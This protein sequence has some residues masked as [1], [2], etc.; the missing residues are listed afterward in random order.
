MRKRKEDRIQNESENPSSPIVRASATRLMKRLRRN[1]SAGSIDGI[2][3]FETYIKMLP[4]T[5]GYTPEEIHSVFV[6][7]EKLKASSDTENVL[8]LVCQASLDFQK[9]SG[10]TEEERAHQIRAHVDSLFQCLLRLPKEQNELQLD[11]DQ[12]KLLFLLNGWYEEITIVENADVFLYEMLSSYLEKYWKEDLGFLELLEMTRNWVTYSQSIQNAEFTTK[13][14][15]MQWLKGKRDVKLIGYLKKC[16]EAYGLD[17]E[18]KSMK[19]KIAHFIEAIEEIETPSDIDLEILSQPNESQDTFVR[20]FFVTANS[21]MLPLAQWD[22]LKG[23]NQQN[24]S[25][26]L[27]LTDGMLLQLLSTCFQLTEMRISPYTA[28]RVLIHALLVHSKDWTPFFTRTLDIVVDLLTSFVTNQENPPET[29][30][31]NLKWVLWIMTHFDEGHRAI[32]FECLRLKQS[33]ILRQLDF[34]YQTPFEFL[35]SFLLAL[36]P[37]DLEMAWEKIKPYCTK[38]GIGC[39]LNLKCFFELPLSENQIKEILEAVSKNIATWIQ[40]S[41]ELEA[42]LFCTGINEFHRMQ[43]MTA[44]GAT[45]FEK[46]MGSVSDF[47]VGVCF[48]DAVRFWQVSFVEMTLTE[49]VARPALDLNLEQGNGRPP[50]LSLFRHLAIENWPEKEQVINIITTLLQSPCLKVS[51]QFDIN[52]FKKIDKTPPTFFKSVIYT[53]FLWCM[54]AQEFGVAKALMEHPSFN[55]EMEAV[56]L[57]GGIFNIYSKNLQQVASLVRSAMQKKQSYFVEV[58]SSKFPLEVPDAQKSC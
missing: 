46:L 2:E 55:W 15:I 3:S 58:L 27:I 50:L 56:R 43:I 20:H 4:S 57:A 24:K 26:Q 48:Q 44:I 9:T 17:P 1:Y 5:G 39:Y 32:F 36:S 25:D 11:R 6:Q 37:Q 22:F 41:E 30:L 21:A 29:L 18:E 34:L 42:L 12:Y 8:N 31:K 33:A 16:Y 14:A 51:F 45:H 47:C 13:E 52:T 10:T 7:I 28:Y 23:L 38:E 49:L 19:E 35:Y 40:R 54:L 53:P